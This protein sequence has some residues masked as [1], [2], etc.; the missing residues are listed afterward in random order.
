[1]SVRRLHLAHHLLCEATIAAGQRYGLSLLC[2][3][4]CLLLHMVTTAYF[5]LAHV[6]FERGGLAFNSTSVLLQAAWVAAHLGRL[7]MI[8]LPCSRVTAEVTCLSVC[9]LG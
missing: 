9:I 6:L 7:L 2:A 5:L 8:A 3:L 4:L 1:M